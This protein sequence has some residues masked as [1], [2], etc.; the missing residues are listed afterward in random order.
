MIS[1]KSQLRNLSKEIWC[2]IATFPQNY[3]EHDGVTKKC[4]SEGYS[5]PCQTSKM[6]CFANTV[7]ENAAF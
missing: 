6:E 5:E 2:T 7:D 1:K 3:R 4:P